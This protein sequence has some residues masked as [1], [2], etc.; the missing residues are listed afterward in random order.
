M[1]PLCR[2]LVF[3]LVLVATWQVIFLTR[4][5]PEY[6]FPAPLSV[7]ATLMSG[8]ADGTFSIAIGVSM[9]RVLVG[10]LISLAIFALGSFLVA[11]ADRERDEAARGKK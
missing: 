9:A 6:L 5:W 8:L 3:L 7:A 11:I 2:K 1:S 10:Y 4:I